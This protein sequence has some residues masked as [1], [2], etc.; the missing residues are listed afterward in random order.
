MIVFDTDVISRMMRKSPP[1]ALVRRMAGLDPAD[2]ATTTINLAELIYGAARS[3]RAGHLMG[4][5]EGW[6]LPNLA[7]LPFDLAA[8]LHHGRLKADLEKL[9]TPLSEP[10]LGIASICISVGATL[11]TG[12][13]R[14][15][16]RVPGLAVEDWLGG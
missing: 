6:L 13:L 3:D 11:A 12:N 16:D 9:G 8:A 7:V 2:Q 1:D 14:H 10:D 5:I 15:F 4:I